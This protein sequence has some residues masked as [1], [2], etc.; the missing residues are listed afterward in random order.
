VRTTR[1][2]SSKKAIYNFT[3]KNR[4]AYR[5]ADGE[6]VLVETGDCFSG[7]A[8]SESD[9]FEDIAMGD[10]NP[11][12]GP[13]SVEGMR[14]GDV[15]CVEVKRIKCGKRGVVMCSPELGILSSEVRRSRTRI[16]TIR[17]TRAVF[18]KDLEIL[19]RP[20]IGVVG[21][22]PRKG[23][24][25]TFHPGDHGGNLDTVEV[26]ERSK[27]YLPTFVDGAMVALGDV[28]AA[29]GDG[30]VCGTGIEV[31]AEVTVRLSKAH[32]VS[33]AR[34]MIET[35]TEWISYAAAKT[36]DQAAKLATQD[37]VRFISHSRGCD[38]EE[39]YMLA[40]VAADLKI[41]QVVDPLM[42]ARMSI[43]KMYL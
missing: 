25:P 28:H 2:L 27:L 29:M 15:L 16:V 17:G 11:A 6:T 21:V 30:E 13:I 22:S 19:L 24:F 43:S 36:L 38:F 18:S 3:R 23:E 8:R 39:A 5:V 20:H 31:P 33:F 42:A 14:A 12:T 41:S 10:V 35:P 9:L 7:L 1:R 32:E 40:S 4:P 34:P 37:M 26:R